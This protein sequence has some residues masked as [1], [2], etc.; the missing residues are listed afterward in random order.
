LG[1]RSTERSLF[2]RDD[3]SLGP[4]NFADR[5]DRVLQKLKFSGELVAANERMIAAKEGL[6]DLVLTNDTLRP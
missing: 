3:A 1:K 2:S 6:M 4:F 5:D